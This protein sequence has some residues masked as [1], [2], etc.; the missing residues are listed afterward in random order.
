MAAND[1]CP[2]CPDYPGLICVVDHQASGPGSDHYARGVR[3]QGEVTRPI[4]GADVRDL[5]RILVG[6][7]RDQQTDILASAQEGCTFTMAG[8]LAI[9]ADDDEQT[10]TLSIP[11]RRVP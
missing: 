4:S 7:D 2:E 5:L 3:W 10:Y 6:A 8:G 11:A 9:A 1:L